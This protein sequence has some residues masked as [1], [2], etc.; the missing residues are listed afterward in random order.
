MSAQ[1]TIPLTQLLQAWSA[2]DGRAFDAVLRD[3]HV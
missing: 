1:P 2:G 3:N